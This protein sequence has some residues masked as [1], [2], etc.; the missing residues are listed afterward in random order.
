MKRQRPLK[1]EFITYISCE[2]GT[3]QA[4]NNTYGS[5]GLGQEAKAEGREKLRTEPL[6]DFYKE[7]KAGQCEQL[8]SD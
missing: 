8:K 2:K 3:Q 6:L 1:E 7:S 4:M 5:S